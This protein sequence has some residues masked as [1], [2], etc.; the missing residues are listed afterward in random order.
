[1]N[2]KVVLFKVDK[3]YLKRNLFNNTLKLLVIKK[4]V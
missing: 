2:Y 1:M 4:V 3:N